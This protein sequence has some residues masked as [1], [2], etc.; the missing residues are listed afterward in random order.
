[1]PNPRPVEFTKLF[2]FSGFKLEVEAAVE[3]C[4]VVN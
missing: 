1:M 3:S 4:I 2:I